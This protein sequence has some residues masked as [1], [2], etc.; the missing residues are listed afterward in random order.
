MW[1]TEQLCYFSVAVDGVHACYVSLA[2][3]VLRK[4]K[5]PLSYGSR[6]HG[7]TYLK[8]WLYGIVSLLHSPISLK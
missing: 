2:C 7:K 3:L 6:A 5:I 8:D 1:G 4:G